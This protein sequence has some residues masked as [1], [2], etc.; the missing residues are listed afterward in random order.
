MFIIFRRLPEKKDRTGHSFPELNT[1]AELGGPWEV[2]FDS[3]RGGPGKIV[4]QKLEDWSQRGENGIKFYSGTAVY[5]K[6][7][8]LPSTIIANFRDRKRNRTR[9]WLDV[10]EVKNLASVRFNGHDLG[11]LWTAPWSVE[12]TDIVKLKGNNM[13][14]TAANLWRNQLIGDEQLPQD[15][16]YGAG[17]NIV[18]W[19][20]WLLKGEPRPTSG[21]YAFSTWKHFSKDSPLLPSGL[22][23][24]VRLLQ[25][26]Q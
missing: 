24:P 10:G 1:V 2:A 5:F 16:E 18:R 19:P 11:V 4:F 21:R 6:E 22:M 15:C 12:I 13:E 26:S 17:G 3:A 14:I 8:D 20:E 7:F 9:L 25:S 23:G